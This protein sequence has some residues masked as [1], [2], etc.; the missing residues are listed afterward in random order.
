MAVRT[1]KSSST[2]SIRPVP[3]P[4]SALEPPVAGPVRRRATS[5]RPPS[6]A[7][8]LPTSARTMR[9]ATPI[10]EPAP[11]GHESDLFALPTA[12]EAPPPSAPANVLL[13]PPVTAS[14]ADLSPIAAPPPASE[15]QLPAQPAQPSELPVTTEPV[16][17]GEPAPPVSSESAPALPLA[18]APAP[19]PA[20]EL[21]VPPAR[22]EEPS[23]AS[24]RPAAELPELRELPKVVELLTANVGELQ[25]LV[26]EHTEQT[27]EA[28]SKTTL[29]MVRMVTGVAHHL[30][31]LVEQV[32]LITT[33]TQTLTHALAR[34]EATLA[35]LHER[36]QEQL[37]HAQ[38]Q[39]ERTHSQHEHTQSQLAL[40]GETQKEL[41]N[42]LT[43]V[44]NEISTLRAQQSRNASLERLE[45]FRMM[46]ELK[47]LRH[48]VEQHGA[49]PAQLGALVRATR[50]GRTKRPG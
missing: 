3:A 14:A 50:G 8:R 43:P 12:D 22:S 1:R 7:R 24:P 35:T 2:S 44:L 16:Q 11:P 18:P 36:T 40:L 9:P 47:Q 30:D 39:L 38:A 42:A 23:A 19:P 31:Q 6:P 21:A 29:Q 49:M 17:T 20:R 48:A 33:V 46:T 41:Q 28:L 15:L 27:T 32:Q 10:E 25:G 34:V 5:P 26:T 37:T 13:P 45:Q 4:V